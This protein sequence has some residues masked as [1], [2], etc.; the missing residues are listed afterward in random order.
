M[1]LWPFKK[2]QDPIEAATGAFKDLPGPTADEARRLDREEEAEIEERKFGG[3]S[4]PDGN[5]QHRSN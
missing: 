3:D 4:L 1:R 2:R 5:E